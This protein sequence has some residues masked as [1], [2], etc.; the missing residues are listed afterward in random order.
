[1]NDGTVAGLYIC[2]SAGEAMAARDDVMAVAGRGLEGDRYLLGT[3]KY[4][5]RTGTGRQI[6]LIEAEV[7]AALQSQHGIP[8]DGAEA[9][10]N[11]V[12]RGLRLDALHGVTFRIGEALLR[13][14]RECTP[15]QYLGELTGKDVL[16]PLAHS[17]G[18]RA[19]ILHGGTI[20]VG[21][22][23]VVESE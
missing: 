13:G 14:M 8:F 5:Q 16:Q 1:M 20:R 7:L 17:G 18:L 22:R 21:D 12:T 23:I 6:T 4:S 11:I 15:C 9:R 10:R 3:G 2:A 19:D